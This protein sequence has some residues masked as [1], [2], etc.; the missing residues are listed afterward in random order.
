MTATVDLHPLDFWRFGQGRDGRQTKAGKPANLMPVREPAVHWVPAPDGSERA[1]ITQ[2]RLVVAASGV[3]GALRHRV[4][5]HYARLHRR[6][7]GDL[8]DTQI[9]EWTASNDA[10]RTLFGSGKDSKDQGDGAK[11]CLGQAGR[12]VIEDA[13]VDDQDGWK[14]PHSAIDRF[15]GG[16][17]HGF[18]FSEALVHKGTIRIELAVADWQGIDAICACAR[19][20]LRL[21]LADLCEGRLALGSKPN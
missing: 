6:F 7:A 21:A 15:T 3:K 13:F 9:K 10:V 12:V 5:F 1:E 20:A 17:R 18:L 19:D 2:R 11:R 14:V 8:A 4:A 16:V